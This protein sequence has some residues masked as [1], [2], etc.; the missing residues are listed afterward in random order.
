MKEIFAFV[1]DTLFGIFDPNY[2]L[3]FNHLYD[4]GGYTSMGFILLLVPLLCWLLFYFLMTYPYG[5]LSHWFI[6]LLFTAL[7][8]FGLTYGTANTEIFSSN[9]QNL[10]NALSNSN[11]SDF[12]GSLPIKYA[13]INGILTLIVGFLYSLFL[14]RFSKIQTHLPF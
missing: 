13:L 10:N 8:V 5:K 11:Y 12:A 9:N 1:Y 6:V 7:V 4:N 3:I 2:Y 14:K